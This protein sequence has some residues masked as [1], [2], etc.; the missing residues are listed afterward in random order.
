M[1]E[2]FSDGIHHGAAAYEKGNI[3][4]KPEVAHNFSLTNNFE[5]E[6]ITI[7]LTAYLNYINDFIYLKPRTENG[8]PQ[9]VLTVRG[10]FPAFDYTQVNARFAGIDLSINCL[11]TN[12]LSINEKYSMVRA[13]DILNDIFMVNI[14]ADRLEST[15]KYSF[16]QREAYVSIGN[17]LVAQQTRVE[18]N[19]DFVPPPSA[20]SIWRMDAGMKIQK[21]S[22]GLSVSN[23]FNLAYREYLNRFRYFTD[24]MGRNVT[25]RLK[26]VF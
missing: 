19:S 26:Y 21:I 11:I 9:T 24:E 12:R 3:N 15:L 6:K 22:L 7:E 18:I 1:N 5:K 4:L 23:A 25:L 16:K 10:A 17:Q 8:I 14:P 20:Y 13:K 2:L